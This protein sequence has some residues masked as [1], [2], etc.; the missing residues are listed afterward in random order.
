MA[1]RCAL[2]STVAE[3]IAGDEVSFD[4]GKTWGIVYNARRT[5]PFEPDSRQIMVKY[6][7]EHGGK[8]KVLYCPVDMKVIRIT[9]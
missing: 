1:T 3:L 2:P 5:N 6:E 7:D 4:S 9:R 8:L